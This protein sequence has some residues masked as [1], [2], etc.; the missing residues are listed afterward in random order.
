MTI[1]IERNELMIVLGLLRSAIKRYNGK[2]EKWEQKHGNAFVP[3]EG[4]RDTSLE[5]IKSY[6]KL[7]EKLLKIDPDL[8]VWYEAKY[9]QE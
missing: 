8:V 9:P 7:A 4:K 5:R 1:E 3:V 6:E 2:R